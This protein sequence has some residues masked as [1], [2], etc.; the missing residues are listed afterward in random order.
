MRGDVVVNASSAASG[1]GGTV[2][3]GS[4]TLARIRET[5]A[6]IDELLQR[7]TDKHPDVTSARNTLDGLTA[8]REAELASL[9]RG[10][11][12][13]AANSGASSSPVY[14]SILLQINQVDVEITSLRGQ[15]AQRR[16][17]ALELQQRLDIAPK[18]EAEFAQINR[19]YEI[20]KAQYTTLLAN[21]EK[22]R[23]GEQADN[24]GSVK[25]EQVQPPTSPYVPVAPH[26][27]LLLVATLFVALLLGGAST[28][29]LHLFNP[30]VGSLQNLMDLIDAPVL[31]VVSSAFPHR[32]RKEA[33]W[34]LFRFLGATAALSGVLVAVLVLAINGFRM[35]LIG[36]TGT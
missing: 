26:R 25:F 11:A 2:S 13:A 31:G 8:R 14:Q 17:K 20:N 5:Q 16:A 7:Y 34:A 3:T 6:R 10:D 35:N 18:V 9:R 29:L 12:G 1:S 23:L 19:D 30:V 36:V 27:I 21:Y 15:L 33:H 4:D 28:Y 22:S 24:A 32:L